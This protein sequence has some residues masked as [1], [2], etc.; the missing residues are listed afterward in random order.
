MAVN[1]DKP[2]RWKSDITASVDM[3]NEWFMN[4]APEAFRNTRI[5]TMKDVEVALRLT[6]NIT[7]VRPDVCVTIPRFFQRCACQPVRPLLSIG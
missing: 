2:D 7:N 1:R 6:E 3:Y 4:F 5:Q